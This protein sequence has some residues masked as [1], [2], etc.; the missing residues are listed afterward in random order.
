[1][2]WPVVLQQWLRYGFGANFCHWHTLGRFLGQVILSHP[3]KTQYLKLRTSVDPSFNNPVPFQLSLLKFVKP[4]II[5]LW[6]LKVMELVTR[7]CKKQRLCICST[8]LVLRKWNGLCPSR[9]TLQDKFN[10]FGTQVGQIWWLEITTKIMHNNQLSKFPALAFKG[11]IWPCLA[12]VTFE[13][14]ITFLHLT[15]W[16]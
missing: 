6:S 8:S 15:Y 14:F 10:F 1:M 4:L 9:G 13:F 12:F 3:G 16:T 7:F 11:Q 5:L 2:T